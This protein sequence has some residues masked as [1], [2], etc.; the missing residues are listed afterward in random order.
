MA[1]TS[2]AAA[3]T[4]RGW[5]LAEFARRARISVG[6]ASKLVSGQQTPGLLL[7][8]RLHDLLHVSIESLAR[9]RSRRRARPHVE[10]R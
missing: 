10:A 3:L 5:T 7:A 6:Y 9:P 4:E 1:E 2:L 8:V